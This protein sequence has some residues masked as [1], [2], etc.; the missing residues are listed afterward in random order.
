M[1]NITNHRIVS[2][3]EWIGERKT[4]S[5]RKRSSIGY[6]MSS[7]RASGLSGSPSRRTPLPSLTGR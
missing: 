3:Q 2:H 7:A 6:A 1:S 4:R 5:R